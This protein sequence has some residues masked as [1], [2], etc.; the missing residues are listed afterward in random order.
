MCCWIIGVR[1]KHQLAS[2]LRLCTNHKL[3]PLVWIAPPVID[4][5]LFGNP[6][7]PRVRKGSISPNS[8][9][10]PNSAPARTG[11]QLQMQPLE[12]GE[13]FRCSTARL[14][15]TRLH[16]PRSLPAQWTF[17]LGPE[18]RGGRGGEGIG[19]GG[20]CGSMN[21]VGYRSVDLVKQ[22]RP[23]Q[24][25]P[26]MDVRWFIITIATRKKKPHLHSFGKQHMC[27]IWK[28]VITSNLHSRITTR[29]AGRDTS[30]LLKQKYINL[31]DGRQLVN[32]DS[33]LCTASSLLICSL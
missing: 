26:Y 6:D 29:E 19:G 7:H 25:S 1:L 17:F 2:C 11:N 21:K 3:P 5:L 9:A 12:E 14:T 22:R 10:G 15:R 8:R 24:E 18:G 33:K 20:P 13:C 30:K 32:F 28:Y 4:R 31:D 16:L 27:F 23:G